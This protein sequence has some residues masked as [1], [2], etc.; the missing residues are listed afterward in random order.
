MRYEQFDADGISYA[1]KINSTSDVLDLKRF[2]KR[3]FT[4]YKTLLNK[5]TEVEAKKLATDIFV[6]FLKKLAYQ[7]IEENDIYIF[8]A[9]GF[10][11]MKIANTA[12]PNREDYVYDIESDGKIWT[13]KLKLDS[14]LNK[15]NKK[16][17]KFRFNQPLRQRMFELI[18]KGHKY[19]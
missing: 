12:N 3:S 16:R 13:P 2:P 18:K 9:E 17:Y 10:G 14:E 8:P 7:L 4:N 15:R 19:G 11:Y 5:K 1:Y 6:L